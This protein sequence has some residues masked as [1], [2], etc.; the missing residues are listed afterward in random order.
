MNNTNT[1][2]FFDPTEPLDVEPIANTPEHVSS[3][4]R[5]CKECAGSGLVIL[6]GFAGRK[7]EPCPHCQRP[8]AQKMGMILGEKAAMV[9]KEWEP[10]VDLEAGLAVSLRLAYRDG[11]MRGFNYCTSLRPSPII[12]PPDH[13]PAEGASADCKKAGCYDTQTAHVKV[14]NTC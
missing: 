7:E 6:T 12:H 4:Q 10:V 2:P 1:G 14:T 13:V 9:A 11:Y 5:E 8:L 3:E